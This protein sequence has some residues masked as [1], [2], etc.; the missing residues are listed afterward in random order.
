M[1]HPLGPLKNLTAA[2]KTE[3]LAQQD[4]IDDTVQDICDL[5]DWVGTLI[6]NNSN[7]PLDGDWDTM[8]AKVKPLYDAV[9]AVDAELKSLANA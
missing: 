2:A 8:I 6:A 4:A 5:D 9:V 7:G 1:S 3:A